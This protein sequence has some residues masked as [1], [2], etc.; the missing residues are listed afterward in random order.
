MST[1][2]S[3]EPHSPEESA[4]S[5]EPPRRGQFPE[6]A[7]G[8]PRY[9]QYAP[10]GYQ[11]PFEQ[12]QAKQAAAQQPQ[13]GPAGTTPAQAPQPGTSTAAGAARSVPRQITSAFALIMLAGVI[14]LFSAISSIFVANSPELRAEL[15]KQINAYPQ[16]A[17]ADL[18]ISAIITMSIVFAVV[19]GFASVALYLLIAFKIRAGKNWARILGTVLAAISLLSLISFNP[20]VILQVGFGIFGMIYCWLPA[21]RDYFKA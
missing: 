4:Q 14:A 6:I 18:D 12:E 5:V 21:N 2:A 10:A 9:G 13:N 20:L 16:L 3:G 17:G 7:P 1:P 15:I 8:V 11:S 19:I